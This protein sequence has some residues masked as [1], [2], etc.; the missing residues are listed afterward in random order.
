MYNMVVRGYCSGSV[1]RGWRADCASHGSAERR[2]GPCCRVAR[3]SG[4]TTL[5]GTDVSMRTKKSSIER[6]RILLVVVARIGIF[7]L[8][9]RIWGL[10]L[11][12][13]IDLGL[14][15][16]LEVSPKVP[17]YRG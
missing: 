2:D 17:V 12:R 5:G 16:G 1:E 3:L 4:G 6:K 11:F 9:T 13:S 14:R 15:F 10:R 8:C 7:R